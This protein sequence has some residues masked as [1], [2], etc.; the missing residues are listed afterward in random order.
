MTVESAPAPTP[1]TERESLWRRTTP[2]SWPWRRRAILLAGAA[3]L[4]TIAALVSVDPLG[5]S[6]WSLLLAIAPA[7]LAA[8]AGFAP[9]PVARLIAW[10]AVAVILAGLI[11]G[12]LHTGLFFAPA[13]IA[14]VVGAVKLSRETA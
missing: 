7:P 12:V 5:V 4:I 2:P 13:L 8:V 11:G 9:V 1:Q 10:V 6:W 3:Q 14:G